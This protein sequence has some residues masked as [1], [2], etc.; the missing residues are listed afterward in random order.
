MLDRYFRDLTRFRGVYRLLCAE[1]AL[2]MAYETCVGP[3]YLAGL[4]GEL[5]VNLGLVSVMAAI[6]WIGA[7]GQIIGAWA[8]ER[9]A[10]VKSY[11]LS[12]ATAG[13][14]L[15]MIPL[16]LAAW[17][18]WR[19]ELT[20]APFPVQRWFAAMTICACLTALLGSA[21]GNAWMYWMRH[22]VPARFQG[23]F[24][25]YRQRYMTSAFVLASLV[26]ACLLDWKPGGWRFGAAIVCSLALL[27]GALSIRL[28]SLVSDVPLRRPAGW[29][30]RRISEIV[31]EPLADPEFRRLLKFGAAYTGAMQLASS[32]FPYY[33]TR[34]LGIPMS[35]VAI[36]G[37][38]SNL[39][40]F[41]AAGYW[42]RRTDRRQ[43]KDSHFEVLWWTGHLISFSPILYLSRDP[44]VIRLIA[45]FEYLISGMAACGFGLAQ[46]KLLLR[47]SRSG[48]GAAQFSVYAAACGMT[49]AVCAFTGGHLARALES[50]GG[51]PALWVVSSVCRFGVLWT[52]CRPS[53]RGSRENARPPE[54]LISGSM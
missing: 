4:A 2:A 38:L 13:R 19:S 10:S 41:I 33:F 34:E 29:K 22:T 53:P 31:G 1:A 11:V 26:A 18:G 27:C 28:H 47:T 52:L 48:L 50:F 20:G 45:P 21:S 23:R 25:G 15:W 6:P 12:L 24:F 51:F 8:F 5:N 17:W 54:A 36:W 7:S 35:S 32:Y 43:G 3:S 44:A 46:T 49:G 39:G 9:N 40:C 14:A 16:F 42:G 30:P 37:G